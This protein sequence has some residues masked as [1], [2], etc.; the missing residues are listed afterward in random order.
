M[1]I[2]SPVLDLGN[3]NLKFMYC[4]LW[5]LVGRGQGR[6]NNAKWWDNESPQSWDDLKGKDRFT[7]VAK[8]CW[9]CEQ[10][11]ESVVAL[12]EF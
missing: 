9:S 2:Q 3:H 12:R 7:L 5:Y 8:L 10:S 4:F 6:N 1:F 11:Y